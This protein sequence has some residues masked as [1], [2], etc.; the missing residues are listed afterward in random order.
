MSTIVLD[1]KQESLMRLGMKRHCV[2]CRRRVKM[3]DRQEVSTSYAAGVA[4]GWVSPGQYVLWCP[5]CRE[6]CHWGLTREIG[7]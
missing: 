7:G 2:S 6:M 3:L 4:M 1:A 5:K